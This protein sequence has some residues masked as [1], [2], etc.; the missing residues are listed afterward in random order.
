MLDEHT[1][2][3]GGVSKMLKLFQREEILILFFAYCVEVLER[4]TDVLQKDITLSSVNHMNIHEVGSIKALA[5]D[6]TSIQIKSI[7]LHR[8]N[9]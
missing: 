5:L 8:R 1:H 9:K 2:F 7:N 4:S 6:K 3:R